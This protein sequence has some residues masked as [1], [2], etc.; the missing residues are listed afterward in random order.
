MHLKMPQ[1]IALSTVQLTLRKYNYPLCLCV[2]HWIKKKVI[3][4]ALPYFKNPCCWMG[5]FNSTGQIRVHTMQQPNCPVT[6][7]LEDQVWTDL[8]LGFLI[9]GTQGIIW[10]YLLKLPLQLQGIF[11]WKEKSSFFQKKA[12]FHI[13]WK[14]LD[15]VIST[16]WRKPW[17]ELLSPMLY[18]YKAFA[19]S[20]LTPLC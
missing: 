19:C 20:S 8:P 4:Q 17:N 18:F 2:H 6:K 13:T 10:N 7:N 15:I 9:L 11:G 1:R 12:E 3:H 16:V 14:T 5:R